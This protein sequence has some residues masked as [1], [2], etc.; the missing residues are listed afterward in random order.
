MEKSDFKDT[1]SEKTLKYATKIMPMSMTREKAEKQLAKCF[2][3]MTVE[4]CI[5]SVVYSLERHVCVSRFRHVRWV[6]TIPCIYGGETSEDFLPLHHYNPVS[7]L[8]FC[9][10]TIILLS[11]LEPGK[12]LCDQVVMG[13][14]LHQGRD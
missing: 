8:R 11:M 1:I 4:G 14:L 7:E 9:K 13:N 2:C 10:L 5:I 3:Q 6:R 12:V